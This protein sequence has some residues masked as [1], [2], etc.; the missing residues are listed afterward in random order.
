MVEHLPAHGPYPPLGVGVCSRSSERQS[1]YLHS[2][3]HEHLVEYFAELGITIVQQVRRRE[4]AVLKL[5]G[6]IPSLLSHPPTGRV[7]R[8]TAEMDAAAADLDGEEHI[9]A[10]EPSRLHG[11][12]VSREQVGGVLANELLPGSR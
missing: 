2:S 12:E 9:Q 5:P 10:A 3:G 1:D 4:D 7:R 11:E 6:Q 8:D